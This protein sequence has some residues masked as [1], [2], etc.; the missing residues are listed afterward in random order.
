MSGANSFWTKFSEGLLEVIF[1]TRCELCEVGE[2]HLCDACLADME[3]NPEVF[4]SE[5]PL[6]FSRR[7]FAYRGRAS[8]A[9]QRLKYDRATALARPMAEI[10][11]A[12][13]IRLSLLDDAIAVPVPIHWTRQ[14]ERGFNQAELLC[15]SLAC[16][17]EREWLERTRATRPQASLGATE[18]RTS[19]DGVF[20]ASR[21]V[22]GQRIV[23]VDDVVTTGE[24]ARACSAALKEAGALEVGVLSF[25]GNP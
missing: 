2:T 24:T 8:Q 14:F 1:P 18:R 9:V 6:D 3:P 20:R 17:V 23:L 16:P 21:Q 5:G 15:R 25:V 13:A 22:K 11:A 19:L 4:A 12:D 10:L 7:V